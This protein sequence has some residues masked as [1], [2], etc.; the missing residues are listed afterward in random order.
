M[1]RFKP[2]EWDVLTRR[3]SV[4]LTTDN[5]RRIIE[6]ILIDFERND[7][8]FRGATQN[9]VDLPLRKSLN[10]LESE[11][12]MDGDRERALYITF[13]LTHNFSRP[14]ER[15]S[16]R[17]MGFWKEENWIFRPE[18]LAGEQRYYDL[19]DL[20][21]G[22]GKFQSH[23]V[24]DEYGLM[25]YGKRDV[26]FRYT[27]A[28][29]LYEE[30]ESDPLRLFEEYDNDASAVYKHVSQAQYEEPVHEEI[31]LTKK[32][33]GLGA[34]KIG[35][36]WLRAIDDHVLDLK[37]IGLL[38]IPVDRHIAHVTNYIYETDYTA[39]NEDHC[40][41]IRNEYLEFCR[42][43]DQASTRLDKALWL[44]GKSW[45]TRGREYLQETLD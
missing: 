17:N 41:E 14:A 29:T 24:T 43:Y 18:I 12:V 22:E 3:Y 15:L 35:P 40:E 5:P 44:I 38:P 45:D 6:E 27:L 33:P 19:F 9:D 20:F 8:I 16:N 32:F 34:E 42:E 10:E 36:L 25:E 39:D 23:P 26:D 4:A 28:H 13:N 30:Y 11:G 37:N 7:G 1:D 2:T 31:R 21:K